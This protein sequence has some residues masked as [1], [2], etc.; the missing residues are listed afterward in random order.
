MAKTVKDTLIANGVEEDQAE[1]IDEAFELARDKGRRAHIFDTPAL[2]SVRRTFFATSDST[3]K[4]FREFQS[5]ITKEL[6][7]LTPDEVAFGDIPD[8]CREQYS[9][10][11]WA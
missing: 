5:I 9:A 1:L 8:V 7:G 11:C 10:F 3:G 2:R 6:R 4:D